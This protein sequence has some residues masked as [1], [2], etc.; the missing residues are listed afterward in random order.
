MN[1]FL[2]SVCLLLIITTTACQSEEKKKSVDVTASDTLTSVQYVSLKRSKSIF[3]KEKLDVGTIQ[4]G[5]EK[6]YIAYFNYANQTDQTVVIEKIKASCG[7]L[8]V[9]Y[10]RT[11]IQ[12]GQK[13]KVKVVL[14]LNRLRGHFRKSLLVYFNDTRPV[15]L[16]IMGKIDT[17]SSYTQKI[18]SEKT[19][20][21]INP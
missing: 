13:G 7:C 19:N 9:N 18:T 20:V 14:N 12:P 4:G 21:I 8:Q 3:L 11:P 16:S 5:K 6:E 1:R 17:N 10:P 2:Y 15:L